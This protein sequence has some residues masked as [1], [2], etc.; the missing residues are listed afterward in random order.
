MTHF[1]VKLENIEK[2]TFAITDKQIHYIRN[3]HRFKLND[4]ITI[5]DE[6]GGNSYQAKIN[7]IKNIVKGNIL[8]SSHKISDF[9]VKLYISISKT[10]R[11]KC[12]IEKCV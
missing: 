6:V 11:F 7:H 3:V 8:S 10:N 2:T 4:E 5:F 12:L 1:Y 9:T